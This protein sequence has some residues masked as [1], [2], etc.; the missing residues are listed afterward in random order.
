V[1]GQVADEVPRYA[2]VE[3]ELARPAALVEREG[4]ARPDQVEGRWIAAGRPLRGQAHGRRIAGRGL[5]GHGGGGGRLRSRLDALEPLGHR[6]HGLLVLLLHGFSAH[7]PI[8]GVRFRILR[9]A[10]A[11]GDEAE[12]ENYDTHGVSPW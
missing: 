7:Q 5:Y 6:V 8:R 9:G 3:E 4:L 10:S 11:P 1:L 2:H 12:S